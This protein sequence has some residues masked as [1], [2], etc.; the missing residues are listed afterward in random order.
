MP[1]LDTESD[2]DQPRRFGG[3]VIGQ[4]LD[5]C[6]HQPY[7]EDAFRYFLALERKRAEQSGRTL[8]L[9]LADL[10][11]HSIVG[12]EI[13]EP[14]ALRLFSGLSLCVRDVD[15]IGWY[16]HGRTLGAVL[17]QSGQT[18]S[19]EA[20]EQIRQRVTALLGRHLPGN[21]TR[22]LNVRVLQGLERVQD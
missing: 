10:T 17:T 2:K 3:W 4:T 12:A 20:S 18:P 6:A 19:V 15:F 14:T 16:R 1:I 8:L 9:L 5:E 22:H 11:A 13:P 7:S 21:V